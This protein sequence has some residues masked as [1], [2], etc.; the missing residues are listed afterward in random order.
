[1]LF[2]LS[3]APKLAGNP[4]ILVLLASIALYA[5][6]RFLFRRDEAVED[7]RRKAIKLAGDCQKC[8]LD[9]LAPVLEDY[10]V[11]DYSAMLHRLRTFADDIRDDATRRQML[12]RFFTTQL[13]QRLQDEAQRRQ[14][15]EALGNSPVVPVSSSSPGVTS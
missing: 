11:G 1:M 10:S 7:R 15:V 3:L 14:I 2:A 5:T 6:G 13:R 4:L 9:F 8:G 12:D